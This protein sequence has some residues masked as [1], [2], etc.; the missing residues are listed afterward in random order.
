MSAN[1]G[2][3]PLLAL[4]EFPRLRLIEAEVEDLF[5][6]GFT[7]NV[8]QVVAKKAGNTV[9]FRAL[10]MPSDN[11]PNTDVQS[12]NDQEV[13]QINSGRQNNTRSLFQEN[14]RVKQ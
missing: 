12:S 1:D 3:C 4:L 9:G 10:H 8:V 5:R 11:Q 14:S 7:T 2:I 6:W 13:A